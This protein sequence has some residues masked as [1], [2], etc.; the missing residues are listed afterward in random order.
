MP[1]TIKTK[2]YDIAWE[3]KLQ[4]ARYLAHTEE[5]LKNIYE[6]RSLRAVTKWYANLKRLYFSIRHDC[7]KDTR[8]E[9]EELF[10]Q[11]N[12]HIRNNDVKKISFKDIDKLHGKVNDARVQEAKMDIP[13]NTKL[14]YG[15]S[16]KE[17]DERNKGG[18]KQ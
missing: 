5:A 12:T 3:R 17:I 18:D 8:E 6:Q 14:T 1:R 7:E 10:E 11:I 2:K 16:K 15:Y 13:T 4:I 9:I